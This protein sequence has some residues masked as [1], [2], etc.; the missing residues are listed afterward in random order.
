VITMNAPNFSWL[1]DEQVVRS[2]TRSD[3][4]PALLVRCGG[5]DLDAVL[6]ALITWCTAP[7]HV[8]RLPGD[9]IFPQA[10]GG[11]LV[12]SDVSALTL[13]QQ[14]DLYDWL[15]IARNGVQLVSVTSEPLWPL[16]LQ[17]R[18][19]EGLFY[20]LNIVTVDAA[21]APH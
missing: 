8:C 1:S 2:L 17:G 13:P 5:T 3:R 6:A 16:V 15:Q 21:H 18:F 10:S 19:L 12:L 7:V 9:L 4:R 20:R 14:I 11:T